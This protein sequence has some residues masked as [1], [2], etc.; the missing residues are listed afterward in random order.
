MKRSSFVTTAA[1][2][3]GALLIATLSSCVGFPPQ[4][5]TEPSP[6]APPTEVTYNIG[7][8]G[9]GGGIVFYDKGQKSGG[10]RY[11]EAA[12]ADLAG[13]HVWITPNA[14]VPGAAD[15]IG[16]GKNN[17][18]LIMKVST[19]N[20]AAKACAEYSNNGMSDWFLPS[21]EELKLMF[22][23]LHKSGLGAFSGSQYWSSTERAGTM[24]AIYI[25]FGNADA[26]TTAFSKTSSF[27]V[28]P[29]R[30]F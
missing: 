29:V 5:T 22:S 18:A 25:N 28:R 1:L 9:P 17:T 13:T 11:L 30:M 10:W 2:I 16:S 14:Q 24:N 4:I 8:K 23:N 6:A 21:V 15:G 7:D 26:Q 20:S 12:P 3:L 27:K 19:G